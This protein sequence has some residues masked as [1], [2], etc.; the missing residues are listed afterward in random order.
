MKT[1]LTTAEFHDSE[2]GDIYALFNACDGV[3][4]NGLLDVRKLDEYG[5]RDAEKLNVARLREVWAHTAAGCAEC[6]SI[7]RG[8]SRL[9]ESVAAIVT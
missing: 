1:N 4:V 9:R 7:V 3:I 5:P 6:E 2:T 8:L